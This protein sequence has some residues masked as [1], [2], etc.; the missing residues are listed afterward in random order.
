MASTRIKD[1]CI[2]VDSYNDNG[3]VKHRRISVGS[4]WRKDDGGE[5]VTLKTLALN[6][7]LALL[8]VK[9]SKNAGDNVIASL[10]DVERRP[11]ASAASEDDE[12]GPF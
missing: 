7:T 1:I 8:N 12:S 10:F 11:D 9:D 6:P 2:S 4:V 5:Y 3:K